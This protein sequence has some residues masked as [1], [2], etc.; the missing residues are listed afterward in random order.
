MLEAT[1]SKRGSRY[2]QRAS[3]AATQA[4]LLVSGCA[5][6]LVRECVLCVIRDCVCVCVCVRVCVCVCVRARALSMFV[7]VCV[8][9]CE[10]SPEHVL[11]MCIRHVRICKAHLLTAIFSCFSSSCARLFAFSSSETTRGVNN[12]RKLGALNGA[13]AVAARFAPP[14][15]PWHTPSSTSASFGSSAEPQRALKF[16][17]VCV[18]PAGAVQARGVDGAECVLRGVPKRCP[19]TCGISTLTLLGTR[20]CSN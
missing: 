17:G 6:V 10:L 16:E 19:H 20:V 8:R 3:Q 15:R 1:G 9:D 7:Y 11:R 13:W 12:R 14:S 4:C 18:A 5:T 2:I